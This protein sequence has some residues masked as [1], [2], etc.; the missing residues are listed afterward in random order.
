MTEDA[1]GRHMLKAGDW[2]GWRVSPSDQ[3]AGVPQPPVQKP[4]DPAAPTVALIPPGS[5]TVGRMPLVEVLRRRR[6]RRKYT[7]DPL[8][9]EELSF[10][11]WSTQGIDKVIQN[12]KATL[13]P[14]PSAG[15]RHPFETYLLV[16]RVTGVAPGLYRYLPLDHRL[17]L[18][19]A[20]AGLAERVHAASYDQ[21]VLQS[22]VTFIWTTLPY[23]TEWRYGSLSH[24]MIAVDAGHVCQN[25]YLAAEA[26]GAGTCAIGAY[27]QAGIDA[28]LG[29]VAG[30]DGSDEFTIYMA[31]VGR[32]P[33]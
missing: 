32:L 2:A 19:S 12:G 17:V 26:I 25:L 27:D 4:F 11:L 20:E 28:V 14:A 6:S 3:Q 15:A 16:N 21:Y 24:K 5:L 10:L 30:V 18:L 1:S 13:R 23:R 9:L 29:A 7:Q 8:T 22:A 31:P 33:G